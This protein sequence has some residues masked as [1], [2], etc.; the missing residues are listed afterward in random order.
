MGGA[1]PCPLWSLR[2]SASL[3]RSALAVPLAGSPAVLHAFWSWRYDMAAS[4][5]V[6]HMRAACTG[7]ASAG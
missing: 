1:A 2:Q 7:S 6:A 4:S 3:S 5:S